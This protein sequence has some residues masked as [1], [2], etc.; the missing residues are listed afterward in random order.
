[1]ISKTDLFQQESL[2]SRTH[3]RPTY[4]KQERQISP[5]LLHDFFPNSP[6]ILINPRLQVAIWAVNPT[7]NDKR[8]SR[9][10]GSHPQL[11][12][13]LSRVD[14]RLRIGGEE[15]WDLGFFSNSTPIVVL[16][17]TSQSKGLQRRHECLLFV[18]LMVMLERR[19][20]IKALEE[21]NGDLQIRV[22]FWAVRVEEGGL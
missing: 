3:A 17:G 14:F 13:R 11:G 10:V 8:R 2:Y 22:F 9:W 21:E 15:P 4:L 16:D 6:M 12:V 1:M 19:D 18:L 7:P 20:E 5:P